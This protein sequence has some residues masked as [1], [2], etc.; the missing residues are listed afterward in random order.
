MTSVL[1]K[2]EQ[3]RD[4]AFSLLTPVILN[5]TI[6]QDQLACLLDVSSSCSPLLAAIQKHIESPT[7]R[8]AQSLVH[9]FRRSGEQR[10]AREFLE[11]CLSQ[12]PFSYEE[13]QNHILLG[14]RLDL[15]Q[16]Q[17][18]SYHFSAYTLFQETIAN[19]QRVLGRT[20]NHTLDAQL[21]YAISL[22]THGKREN[23]ASVC[24]NVMHDIREWQYESQGNDVDTTTDDKNSES[25]KVEAWSRKFITFLQEISS[26]VQET[27]MRLQLETILRQKSETTQKQQ[28]YSGFGVKQKLDP[29]NA[30]SA[31]DQPVMLTP[32][33]S[34]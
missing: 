19:F 26:R 16:C 2:I 33:L 25:Y 17:G 30:I 8:L 10:H 24:L 34:A 15:A 27:S 5:N 6:Q 14:L 22:H 9:S 31:A 20:N 11:T 23:A 29:V 3:A 28:A 7:P 12:R 1:T 4:S 18:E 32:H 21:K 13:R